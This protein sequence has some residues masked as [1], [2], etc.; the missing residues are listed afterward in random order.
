MLTNRDLSLELKNRIVNCYIYPVLLY[1]VKSW[2]ISEAMEKRIPA[3]QMWIYRI[4]WTGRI[5]NNEVLNRMKCRL[6]FLFTTIN[7][8]L[9]I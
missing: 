4:Y 5:T 8:N 2:T 1:E 9:N 3:F 6:Q 7:E